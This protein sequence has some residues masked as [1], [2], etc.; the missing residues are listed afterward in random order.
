MADQTSNQLI[1]EG[2]TTFNAE[3]GWWISY[4]IRAEHYRCHA[5]DGQRQRLLAKL[6][7]ASTVTYFADSSGT[8][9]QGTTT[10]VT[11]TKSRVQMAS[12]G[13]LG[14]LDPTS[15][16]LIFCKRQSQARTVLIQSRSAAHSHQRLQYQAECGWDY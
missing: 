12:V 6:H 5:Q 3:T 8:D 13:D 15:S 4:K 1:D 11:Y 10:G 16:S 7:S 14:F 2:N 9:A